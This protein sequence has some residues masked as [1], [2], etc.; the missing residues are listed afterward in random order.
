MRIGDPYRIESDR[1][2]WSWATPAL[3]H[4]GTVL[5]LDPD[6]GDLSRMGS[7]RSASFFAPDAPSGAGFFGAVALRFGIRY[8]DQP[9]LP[10]FA[11]SGGDTLRDWDENPFALPDIRLLEQ[12]RETPGPVE[13]FEALP[14]LAPGEVVVE[15]GAARTGAAARGRL[16]ILEKTPERLVLQADCPEPT[17]LFVLR[18]FWPYRRI[19]V[20]GSPAPAAP[21]QL[22]FSAVRLPAGA[23]RIEWREEVPGFAA[24]R[25]GPALFL[26]GSAGLL[27]R[28]SAR[29]SRA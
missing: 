26:L 3:W 5:N 2:A 16:G 13:A 29:G 24:S 20:D 19:L 27:V 22:A 7:F 4:R 23:H 9:P 12:W 8:R 6:V 25:W 18:E 10:G 1:Q 28:Q 21:A 15:T 17:W 14:G 11:R